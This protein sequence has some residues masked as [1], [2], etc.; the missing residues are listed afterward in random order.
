MPPTPD[1]TSPCTRFMQP[2]ILALLSVAA[3]SLTTLAAA[4][5]REQARRIHDRIAG[6]PPSAEVQDQMEAMVAAGNAVDAAFTA[7]DNSSFYNVTLKNLVAPWT[8]V[9]RTVF[10]PLN[11]YTATVIGMVRDDVP[12]DTLF[13]ADL[14]YVGNSS[15]GLPAYSMLN[16][17]HYEQLEENGIDLRTG[18]VATTQSAATD[19]P[20]EAIAGVFTTRAAGEAFFI[21]GTNRAMFRFAMLNHL[22]ND[23]EQVHD[24]T[25]AP[26]RIRQDVSRSPGGDSRIFLNNCIGC[27]SGMDPLAQAFAYYEFD[28]ELGRVIYSPNQVQAKYHI[29]AENFRYGYATP[30]DQW[31]NYWRQ[32]P[33]SRLGWD[34]RLPGSG[35]GAASMGQELAGSEAFAT[36]QVSKVFRAVCL[37]EPVDNSDHQQVSNMVN[38]FRGANYQL[39]QVFAES[40]AYCMG[41]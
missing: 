24:I 15:L 16:N 14:L 6:V 32:G 12:F 2:T 27:H 13:S 40:A 4:G 21:D 35:A 28:E 18:L 33:N 39:K 29:N 7:M 10:V 5:P 3:M 36:C 8:N 1:V 26:D 20:A 30:D 25:R 19:L 31:S 38:S 23:M 34:E 17:A 22:C 11:D 41:D 9:E 37:R